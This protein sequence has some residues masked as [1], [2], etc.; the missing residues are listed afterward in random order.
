[1]CDSSIVIHSADC[2]VGG[3]GIIFISVNALGRLFIRELT[4]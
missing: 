4:S 2:F 1:M 3:G